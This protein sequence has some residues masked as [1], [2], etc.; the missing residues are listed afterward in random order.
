MDSLYRKLR[1][2]DVRAEKHSAEPFMIDGENKLWSL[3]VMGTN[4]PVSLLRA[5][6]YY[7]GENFCLYTGW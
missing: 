1:P 7:N 6:F 4:S 5:V 3:E 2:E